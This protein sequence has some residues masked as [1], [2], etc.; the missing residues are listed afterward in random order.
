M[1]YLVTHLVK[2]RIASMYK[3]SRVTVICTI[4]TVNIALS[5]G[6]RARLKS[7]RYAS[8]ANLTECFGWDVDQARHRS[9][10]FSFVLNF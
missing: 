7:G 5:V 9:C 8:C 4:M 3:I 6:E 2:I 1:K 10:L